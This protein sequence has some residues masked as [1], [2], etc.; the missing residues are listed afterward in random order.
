MKRVIRRR[1]FESNSSSMHTVTVQ[2][3][4]NVDEAWI[5]N[6]SD[7]GVIKIELDEYGWNGDGCWS[8]RT[9]LAYALSMILHTEYPGF[10]QYD[11]SFVVDSDVLHECLGYKLLMDTIHKHIPWCEEI[12]IKK[13]SDYF[14]PYGYIDHQSYEDYHSLQDFLDDWN[15]DVERYLFDNGVVVHIDNDNH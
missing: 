2:G 12:E 4:K 14:Y 13:R 7:D 9:K 10:N 15:V 5:P 11:E 3:K 6:R 1:M 8:F